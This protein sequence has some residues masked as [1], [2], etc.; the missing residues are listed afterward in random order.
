MTEPPLN[1]LQFPFWKDVFCKDFTKKLDEIYD[2]QNQKS[3]SKED[4][5]QLYHLF[6][7][8]QKPSLIWPNHFKLE[9]NFGEILFCI[10]IHETVP[11]YEEIG[12][13]VNNT[14]GK[15]PSIND[16]THFLRFFTPPSHFV[17]HCSKQDYGVTSPFGRFSLPLSG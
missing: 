9:L 4:I 11:I 8:C 15:G 7:W 12:D 3:K 14:K 6:Q 13:V 17:T 5:L 16:I 1:L 2:L 10:L